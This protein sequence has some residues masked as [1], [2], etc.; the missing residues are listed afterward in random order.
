MGYI[1]NGEEKETDAD[2]YLLEPDLS[3]EAAQAIAA[4]EGLALTDAHWTV[5]RYFRDK[6]REDGQTPNFRH[7]MKDM[8]EQMPGADAKLMYD[9][10]PKDGPAKQAV[11]IAGLPK[12]FGKG[13]Y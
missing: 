7:F 9:L 2:G 11:K 13:G 10:F 12:P 1:I 4:A 5:I 3:D 8:A 6:Y